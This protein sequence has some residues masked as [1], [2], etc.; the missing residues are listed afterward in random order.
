M[1]VANELGLRSQRM[2]YILAIEG[3]GFP[4]NQD[5]AS[6]T[7]E[8]TV[9][10]TGDINGD[11]ATQLG[12]TVKTGLR[13]PR[14]FSD[15]LD[16]Y[17]Y[18]QSTGGMTFH[19]DDLNDSLLNAFDLHWQSETLDVL[20]ADL[21]YRSLEVRIDNATN[22]WSTGDV[23]WIAGRE[24]VK[25]GTRTLVSGTVYRYP[26]STRGYLGTQRGKSD[27]PNTLA[28][29]AWPSSTE[30][31]DR[32]TVWYDRR[33]SLFAH[34]PGESAANIVWLYSGKLKA[35]TTESQGTL[36]V[37]ETVHDPIPTPDRN[38]RI[39]QE[40]LCY[41]PVRILNGPGGTPTNSPGLG[42]RGTTDFASEQTLPDATLRRYHVEV[43]VKDPP[44]DDLIEFYGLRLMG[45]YRKAAGG[46]DSALTSVGLQ[47]LIDDNGSKIVDTMCTINGALYH[48]IR[49]PSI[50]NRL[51]VLD[52]YFP[53]YDAVN[54][55][56]FEGF[57][58]LKYMLDSIPE[59]TKRNRF[60]V[61]NN[62]SRNIVDIL[63]CFLTSYNG[64]FYR[65]D[66]ASSGSTTTAIKFT[67]S[68]AFT[69]D[70]WAGFALH[71]TEDSNIGESRIILSNTADTVTVD[72][73]FS[74]TPSASNEYQIRN[75]TH[76]VLPFGW[77]LQVPHWKIDTDSFMAM[78][79]LY[80]GADTSPFAIDGDDQ[81]DIWSV[82]EENI[83]RPYGLVMRLDRTTGKISLVHVGTFVG[84]GITADTISVAAD[85]ILELG[86]I[87]LTPRAPI[88][89]VKLVTRDARHVNAI[90]YPDAG[91]TVGAPGSS[92]Q[93][94]DQFADP[95]LGKKGAERVFRSS[96]LT[97]HY[98]KS[99]L[100][101]L[102]LRAMFNSILDA[103]AY[104]YLYYSVRE[105]LFRGRQPYP[106]ASI[107][108]PLSY[109][110]DVQSGD[111]LSITDTTRF[112]P[113]NPFTMSRGWTNVVALVLSTEITLS[114]DNPGIRCNI[115]LQPTISGAL[116]APA[117]RVT[118]KGSD[119]NGT[120]LTVDKD[121]FSREPGNDDADDWVG[122]AVNDRI[123]LYNENGAAVATAFDAAAVTTIKGFG[124]NLATDPTD[125]NDE[126]IYTN[127]TTIGATITTDD[128]VSFA[129]W[130]TS[131]NT[132]NMDKYAAWA[133]SNETIDSDTTFYY[134]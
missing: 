85:N 39:S 32:N 5:D 105:L 4:P 57:A 74:N 116:L 131:S 65:A 117:V 36:W 56:L 88:Y 68:P 8:G 66:T 97:K 37:F 62:I 72:R 89:E 42:S 12:C 124:S 20:Q 84:D 69:T 33:V 123:T 44:A 128:Y 87:D 46:T 134:G 14:T 11:L 106:E 133:D 79:D 76:D 13:M 30:I 15:S 59:S 108:L 78:K 16:P 24:S 25:L 19:V 81:K 111:Y 18:E 104:N 92:I 100:T 126:R 127:A 41:S 83:L 98:P 48:A 109:I 35:L 53:Q 47:G 6:G 99:Q 54:H 132:T 51:L 91:G 64:E 21:T 114:K 102:T 94:L 2:E 28:E 118:G 29:L 27:V 61:D 31:S 34:V 43:V 130:S 9:F 45:T 101:T 22:T 112:N 119:G 17:T 73:A 125:A 86:N 38:R 63:L 40:N 107:L 7:W 82:L 120:Y 3:I 90:V 52:P 121:Q 1:T 77:G 23:V 10:A 95:L 75:H 113:I 49:I 67:G 70:E 50:A 26:S 93:V 122:L 96:H 58:P 103:T 115:Q 110:D 80:N 129:T 55:E 60:A 71:A